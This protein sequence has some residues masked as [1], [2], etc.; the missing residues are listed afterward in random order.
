M[1]EDTQ[2][3]QTRGT[4]Y[5]LSGMASG[6]LGKKDVLPRFRAGAGETA[7]YS[8][9]FALKHAPFWIVITPHE[10]WTVMSDLEFHS[11]PFVPSNEDARH[12]LSKLVAKGRGPEAVLK[13]GL[14]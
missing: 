10:A 6:R 4:R 5:S 9:G 3:T 2:T 11:V 1:N 14:P 8:Y 7:K 12:V 13:G